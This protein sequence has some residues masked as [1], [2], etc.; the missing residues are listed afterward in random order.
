MKQARGQFW[1]CT[2]VFCLVFAFLLSFFD[3][4]LIL[5]DTTP[6]GGDTPS[7]FAT[8]V[9]FK[10]LLLEH[11]Q[12]TGWE[13]GNLA[14][15]P[16]F[17]YYFPLAFVIC[18]LLSLV[19]PMTWSF[20]LTTVLGTFLLPWAVF[21]FLRKLR[22]PYPLPILGAASTLLFLFVESQTMWGANILSTLAGEFSY[23]LALA[24]ALF[25]MGSFYAEIEG[26]RRIWKN[27]LLLALTG[28]S[29]GCALLVAGSVPFFCVLRGP[30]TWD[31][32]RYYVKVNALVFMLLAFWLVPWLAEQQY[33]TAF[34]FRWIFQSWSELL[35]AI[36]LPAYGL[37]LVSGL[38]LI[39]QALKKEP[40]K[41][42]DFEAT[43][44]LWFGVLVALL[45]YQFGFQLN[46]VDIRFL[47]VAQLFLVLVAA[48]F[49]GQAIGKLR[50]HW[51]LLVGFTLA[52]MVWADANSTKAL[53]WIRWNYEGFERKPHWSSL[54]A[55][56]GHLKG[57]FQDPRV[58]YEHSPKHDQFGSIRTFESLPYFSGR[59]TL[60]GV[61]TQASINSPFIFHLQSEIS[62]VAS[63]PLPDYHCSSLSFKR[64]RPRLRLFNTSHL[65]LRS[66]KA[67]DAAASD[68][69]LV[70]EKQVP[71]LEIYRISGNEDKYVVPLRCSPF[72]YT[73][74]DWKRQS[75]RWYRHYTED[76]VPV[77]MD[78]DP[79]PADEGFFADAAD[80]FPARKTCVPSAHSCEVEEDLEYDRIRIRTSCL[81]H[82]LLIKMSY[83]PRWRVKGASKVY[84]ATPGFM[85]VFPRDQEVELWL[86]WA[87]SN[88]LGVGLTLIAVA[89]GISRAP[90]IRS[91]D[92]LRSMYW[93]QPWVSAVEE[94]ARSHPGVLK[95]SVLCIA[96]LFLGWL[97]V[98]SE[99][100]DAN[101]VFDGGMQHYSRDEWD[102]AVANFREV[103]ESSPESGAGVNARFFWG[104]SR[105]RQQRWDEAVEMLSGLVREYPQSHYIAEAIYHLGLMREREGG[106]GREFFERVLREHP[107]SRWAEPSSQQLEKARTPEP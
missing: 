102:Q 56:S 93:R 16:L 24:I 85:L 68:P 38:V 88:Y 28:L 89:W 65:I 48:V 82:P 44:Y 58:A 99:K 25:Y 67:K 61:Y 74:A 64:A 17:Q 34:N 98:T 45:L 53:P 83:H 81:E 104:L 90:P 59:S 49:L 78:L 80:L 100:D 42:R 62:E 26:K 105:Y 66:D 30:D 97:L 36:L 106:N 4:Y 22:F 71:P 77:V 60:E 63:C 15:F 23:S 40:K 95:I 43:L 27:V 69:G 3:P 47:P 73:G 87:F 91:L 35:P 11:G 103:V 76:S 46:V 19:L 50:A 75:Y 72:L 92:V 107:E 7:H 55:A 96:G 8:A 86:G 14:G 12:L 31:R 94:R 13:Y 51:T 41:V 70:L 5:S 9:H 1:I 101:R 20:K 33:M 52:C 57:S 21:Y 37:A 18:A 10:E 29:H 2:I 79:D 32:L 54:A 39:W 6:A 84:L